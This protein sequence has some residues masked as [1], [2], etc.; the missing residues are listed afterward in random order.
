VDVVLSALGS[1]CFREQMK[2]TTFYSDT[3][4]N[5][6]QAMRKEGVT[7]LIAITSAGVK[8]DKGLLGFIAN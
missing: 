3:A 7:R 2:E 6:V 8:H 1:G 5:I 4:T